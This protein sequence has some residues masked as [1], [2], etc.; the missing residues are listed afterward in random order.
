M[1]SLKLVPKRFE[2][3]KAMTLTTLLKVIALG[4]ILVGPFVGATFL[5]SPLRPTFEGSSS[6][7]SQAAQ[8]RAPKRRGPVRSARLSAALSPGR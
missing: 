4:W 1:C 7:F 6:F 5:G 2:T 8:R 3:L